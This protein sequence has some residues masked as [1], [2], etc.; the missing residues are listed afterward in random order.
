MRGNLDHSQYGAGGDFEVAME[1]VLGEVLPVFKN[2]PRSARELLESMRGF[3]AAVSPPVWA[4]AEAW[5]A[6]K[7]SGIFGPITNAP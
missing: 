3:G 5:I 1:D 6:A 4:E 2:R 7:R